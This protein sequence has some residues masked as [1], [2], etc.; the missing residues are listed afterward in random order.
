M[1]LRQVYLKSGTEET[2]CWL[3]EDPRV[4]EGVTL[5]LVGDDTDWTVLKV[6]GGIDTKE[7]NR[8]WKVG[9]LK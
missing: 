5:N 8:A 6:Y 4:R 2:V 9:G 3:P 1:I 7:I